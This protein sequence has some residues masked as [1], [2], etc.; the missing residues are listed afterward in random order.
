MQ[1]KCPDYEGG[2]VFLD[3]HQPSHS[4]DVPTRVP[5]G[6][7]GTVRI[8]FLQEITVWMSDFVTKIKKGGDFRKAGTVERICDKRA[9][10]RP[11]ITVMIGRALC[12]IRI[13][14]RQNRPTFIDLCANYQQRPLIEV[15]N[16][17]RQ[18]GKIKVVLI[19]PG[20]PIIRRIG[21]IFLRAASEYELI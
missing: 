10:T 17:G 5:T 8:I 14:C 7:N 6:C 19:H 12:Y 9:V 21:Q 16:R 18:I 1:P 13:I 15:D 3:R 11:Q 4:G 2:L 20:T